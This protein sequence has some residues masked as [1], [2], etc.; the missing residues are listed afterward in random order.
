MDCVAQLE[1]GEHMV[2]TQ[3]AIPGGNAVVDNV[4]NLNAESSAPSYN[5]AKVYVPVTLTQ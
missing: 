1:L 5:S 3:T 2:L 4:G